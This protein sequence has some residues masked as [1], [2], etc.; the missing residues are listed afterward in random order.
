MKPQDITAYM[1]ATSK[2]FT[3][4]AQ[5]LKQPASYIFELAIRQN[6]VTA[7]VDIFFFSVVIIL[8]IPYVRLLKWGFN[9]NNNG[10][11]N[12]YNNEGIAMFAICSGI[13]LGIALLISLLFFPQDIVSRLINPQWMA[14]QDIIGMVKSSN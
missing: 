2:G 12:F 14:I 5:T 13:L 8:T 7:I 6:Y 4:L 3:H 10:D 9:L 1:D 11:T